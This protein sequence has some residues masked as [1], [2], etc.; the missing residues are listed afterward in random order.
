MFQIRPP[1]CRTG[2]WNMWSQGRDHFTKAHT[3][4]MLASDD[5]LS[6]CPDE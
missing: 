6:G 3:S 5:V 1:P 4:R 2:K